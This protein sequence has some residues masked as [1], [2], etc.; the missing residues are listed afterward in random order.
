[1]ATLPF[2][3]KVWEIPEDPESAAS[4]GKSEEISDI[5]NSPGFSEEKEHSA[6][7]RNQV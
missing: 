6:R 5:Y 2:N 7:N 1:M 4:G 3:G